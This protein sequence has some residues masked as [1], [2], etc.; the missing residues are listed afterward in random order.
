MEQTTTTT[1]QKL[2]NFCTDKS[3]AL[4]KLCL[5]ITNKM[6]KYVLLQFNFWV[7]RIDIILAKLNVII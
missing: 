3:E 7:N 2:Q 6:S 4:L 5:S 1:V